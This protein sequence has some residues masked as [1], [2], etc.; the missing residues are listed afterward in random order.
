MKKIIFFIVV[1]TLMSF[2]THTSLENYKL[3]Q[4]LDN[5]DEMYEYV[6]E[7][8]NNGSM[9]PN[10]AEIYLELIN[11]SEDKIKDVQSYNVEDT[12]NYVRNKYG[13]KLKDKK[14]MAYVHPHTTKN[15]PK[16]SHTLKNHCE[17]MKKQALEYESK[18]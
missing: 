15:L 17:K 3:N 4:V 1:I 12:I 14:E 16:L 7:D 2:T 18:N 5:L 9:D 13:I 11:D 8:V 6:N 10:I